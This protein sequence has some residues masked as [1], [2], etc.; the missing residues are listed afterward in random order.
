MKLGLS[1]SIKNRVAA[2]DWSPSDVSSLI[3]WYKYDTGI[4][5]DGEDNIQLWVDQEGGNKLIASGGAEESPSYDHGFVKFVEEG[6]ILEWGTPLSLGTFS[7]YMRFETNDVDD[8][9]LFK[10]GS[11]DWIKLHDST[12]FRVK[13][14]PTEMHFDISGISADTKVNLGVDRASNGDVGVFINN[15]A[16]SVASGYTANVATSTTFDITKVGSPLQTVKIY[17]ILIFNDVLSSGNKNSLNTY[18]NTI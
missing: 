11:S 14:H 1:N 13:I 10:G 17:E 15:S 4:S 7:I 16:Q 6:D 5:A 9:W 3:H 18:L 12:N 2:G 8:D